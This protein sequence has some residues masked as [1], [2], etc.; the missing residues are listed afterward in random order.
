MVL[1]SPSIA[2]SVQWSARAAI[3]L[4]TTHQFVG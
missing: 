3:M 2:G 4:L 1:L